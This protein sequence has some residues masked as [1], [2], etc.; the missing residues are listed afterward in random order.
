[1]IRITLIIGLFL[2]SCAELDSE[3]PINNIDKHEEIVEHAVEVLSDSVNIDSIKNVFKHREELIIEQ[4]MEIRT[5]DVQIKQVTKELELE[6]TKLQKLN[7]I[8]NDSVGTDSI[9]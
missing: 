4:E 7:M 8:I 2:S 9:N 5:K 1:M 3:Y 6:Q